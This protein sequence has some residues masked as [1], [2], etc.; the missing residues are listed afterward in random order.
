MHPGADTPVLYT[1]G[2]SN[3]PIGRFVELLRQQGIEVLADVRST[4]FSRFNP[5]FNKRALD[6]TLA[7]DGIRYCFLGAELGARSPDPAHH[8]NGRVSYRKLAG[9]EA[10]QSGL[11][12][13]LSEAK[14]H[15]TAI[16]CAEK[17]PLDCHR[18]ILVAREVERMGL[19]VTHILADGSLETNR[20][21]L[22]RLAKQLKL[23]NGDLF[24]S[25][26]DV[27][28]RAYDIRGGGM[29]MKVGG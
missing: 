19:P 20:A 3:H 4:P 23:S 10:F 27:A 29:G 18:T 15:R 9:S 26:G 1:I 5:Q 6:G 14:R 16:L 25:E 2:H 11:A 7:R 13:L 17:E 22:A 12:R 8:E 24:Q 28:E 21:A